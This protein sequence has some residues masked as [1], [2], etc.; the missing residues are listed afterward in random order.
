MIALAL[1]G[2]STALAHRPGLSY[3]EIGA[4]RLTLTFAREELAARFPAERLGE[5]RDLL[6][7][8]TLER[9]ELSVDG[10]PCALGAPEIREVSGGE[11]APGADPARLDGVALSAPLRCPAGQEGR[12]TAAFLDTLEQGHRHVVTARGAPVAVLERGE[13]TATFRG[14]SDR[15]AVARRFLVLGVE[16]IVTG[17]D[18][19]LFLGGLLLVA[20]RL[21]SMLLIVTGF[22]LAHSI[23]LSAAALGWL[24]LPAAVVE[25]A[26]AATIVFVGLENLLRPSARRRMALTFVL[27]LVH[28]FGFASLLAGIGLPRDALLLALLCFNGGVELGQAAVAALVLPALLWLRRYP[29]WE[30]RGVPALSLLVA[31]CGLGWLIERTVG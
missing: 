15:W 22:T 3:A 1:L 31:L 23:T 13:P 18:H 10:R 19:L 21:R 14:A 26:I 6:A 12:Y 20:D 5:A 11:P 17:Y 28:G 27:G 24:A 8:A 4:D 16:H 7:A 29:S 9:V 25:P 2:L 30:R